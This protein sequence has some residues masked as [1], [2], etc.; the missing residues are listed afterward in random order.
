MGY[1][2]LGC[3]DH[4]VSEVQQ[5]KFSVSHISSDCLPSLYSEEAWAAFA[6]SWDELFP[7]QYMADNGHYRLRRYQ[8]YEWDVVAQRF[9]ENP[10]QR[11]YQ[12]RQYNLLNGGVFREYEPFETE[13]RENPSF[14]SLRELTAS[15]AHKLKPTVTQ[16][17]IEAH[18]FRILGSAEEAGHPV[19]EGMHKDGVDYVF[20]FFIDR[21]AVR[22]GVSK[23]Y[24]E[25]KRL[26]ATHELTQP[27]ELMVIDDHRVWHHVTPIYPRKDAE[28]AYRDVVVLTFKAI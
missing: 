28:P 21:Q 7:D 15:V 27:R 20:V 22:G 23:V 1:H 9:S 3:I 14:L 18:Q 26:V 17:H 19:P 5:N 4:I 10:D 24:D 6:G 25:Q 13:V 12:S 16:W 11:H 2:S 8:V